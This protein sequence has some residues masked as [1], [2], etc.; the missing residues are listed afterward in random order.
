VP[1]AELGLD[2]SLSGMAVR[3]RQDHAR[4]RDRACSSVMILLSALPSPRL[5]YP[6]GDRTR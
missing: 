5:G 2:G 6:F 3:R 4:G 1:P